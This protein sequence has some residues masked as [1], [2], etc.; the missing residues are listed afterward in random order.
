MMQSLP[1]FTD[2]LAPIPES[3]RPKI[4]LKTDTVFIDRAS[5]AVS[6]PSSTGRLT[7]VRPLHQRTV[8]EQLFA[9]LADAKI[10]T[11]KIAMHLDPAT[12]DRLFRQLDIL[13]EAD[14]WSEGDSPLSLP[15]YKSLVRAMLV[16]RVNRRPSLSLMPGGNILALWSDGADRLS[17]E[18]LPENRA[19]WFVQHVSTSGAERATGTTAIERLRDV[20]HPYDAER[21][22]DGS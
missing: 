21:W 22:F 13:H 14:E 7:S 11:S 17:I 2:S 18:F 16:H 20:L 3:V 12:R 15:S 19:R 8:D 5:R 6:G 10:W 9:A 4:Y 1:K